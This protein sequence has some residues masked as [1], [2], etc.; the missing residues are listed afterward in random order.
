MGRASRFGLAVPLAFILGWMAV[1]AVRAGAADA[2]DPTLHES[3]GVQYSR[4]EPR[5]E[6][7]AEAHVHFLK[8]LEMRP[9]SPYTW[10][11]LASAK[12]RQGDTGPAFEAALRHAAD[13]GPFEPEVQETVA[14]YGLAVWDEVAAPT[15]A[16]ID[17]AVRAGMRRNPGV[18]LQIAQ[19]RGR[20]AVACS[21]LAGASRQALSKWSQL[22][23]SME[24]TS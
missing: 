24:A 14:F 1:F 13:L 5:A 19:R 23:L 7:A 8:A 11:N 18:M 22:C 21:H 3:K 15:R 16:A 9:T 20:L 12:Y 2:G 4:Q 10:A 17:R 6:S